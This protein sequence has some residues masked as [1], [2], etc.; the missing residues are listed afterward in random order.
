[1]KI[2]LEQK[3]A[4]IIGFLIIILFYVLHTL[5]PHS[6][7]RGHIIALVLTWFFVLFAL[8]SKGSIDYKFKYKAKAVSLLEQ[9]LCPFCEINSISEYRIKIGYT[10]A[11]FWMGYYVLWIK[12]RYNRDE[13]IT[14]VPLCLNCKDKFLQN[15]L[16]NPSYSV[17]E[18]KRG[19]SL[20]LKNTYDKSNIF[21][22]EIAR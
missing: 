7:F 3:K 13:F 14:S 6:I 15:K 8:R 2:N 1:M 4:F 19:F 18:R 11:N 5:N 20:G 22:R 10:K 12:Y 16:L 21:I 17:L 9:R